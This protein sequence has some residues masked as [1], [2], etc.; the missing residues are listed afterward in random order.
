MATK[1]GM[2]ITEKMLNDKGSVK[3]EHTD[4]YGI[5]YEMTLFKMGWVLTGRVL[6]QDGTLIFHNERGFDDFET[7]KMV[8]K[9]TCETMTDERVAVHKKYADMAAKASFTNNP[10][11]AR[12]QS[13][14]CSRATAEPTLADRLREALL[15][16]FKQAA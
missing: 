8:W 12:E 11:V 10:Q 15:R 7:A 5:T 14:S 9:S 13:A 4:S 2:K 3:F 16:Q 6:A 1:K